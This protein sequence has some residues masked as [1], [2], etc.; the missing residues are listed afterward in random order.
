[1]KRIVRID[2]T[3]HLIDNPLVGLF[4]CF[5]LFAVTCRLAL[6]NF[7]YGLFQYM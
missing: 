5:V 2:L 3:S 7:T 1:M 6:K 4:A